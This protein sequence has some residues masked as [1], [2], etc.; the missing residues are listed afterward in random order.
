MLAPI[1][2]PA[3]GGS[4]VTTERLDPVAADAESADADAS[5]A[6]AVED[7]TAL[8]A[9]AP[10]IGQTTGARRAGGL[11]N[12]PVCPHD[13]AAGFESNHPRCINCEAPARPAILMFGDGNWIDDESQA[14]RWNRWCD[15]VKRECRQRTDASRPPLKVAVMEIGCGG[16]VTT[17]RRTTESFLDAVIEAGGSC[18]AIRINPDLPLP[19]SENAD[20]ARFVSIMSGGLSALTEIDRHIAQLR[21]GDSAGEAAAPPTDPA[22][23]PAP[24]VGE[25]ESSDSVLAVLELDFETAAVIAAEMPE[26]MQAASAA[27]GPVTKLADGIYAVP[28]GSASPTDQAAD[29]MLKAKAEATAYL[30]G[31]DLGDLDGASSSDSSSDSDNASDEASDREPPPL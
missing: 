15:A 14:Q 27:G 24:A 21:R 23:A 4:D 9:A 28:S 8:N 10:R 16:N 26:E 25:D 5:P 30:L 19:D 17:V 22:N 11:C 18:H 2:P 13:A 12:M 29:P 7:P 1:G 31:L 6:Q 20:A 3:D